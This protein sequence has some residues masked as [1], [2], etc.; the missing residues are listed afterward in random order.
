MAESLGS[1]KTKG[2]LVSVLLLTLVYVATA[3][4]FEKERLAPKSAPAFTPQE[5]DAIKAT[6]HLYNKIYTDLYVSDGAT[7]RL[8]D[9]PASKFLRHEIYKNLGFLRDRNALLVYDMASIEFVDIKGLT[10]DRAEAVVFEEWN[11]QYKNRKTRVP[12]S[13]LKGMG[14]GFRYL[15]SRDSDRWKVID[16]TPADLEKVYEHG[17]R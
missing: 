17:S 4:V 15:L 13:R 14:K 10:P 2:F 12:T 6:V 7:L 16:Y 9:F 1:G 8:D 3:I 5:E 11:Y